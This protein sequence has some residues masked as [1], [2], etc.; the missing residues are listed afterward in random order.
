MLHYKES[1]ESIAFKKVI[2][3]LQNAHW[4]LTTQ[5]SNA[6]PGVQCSYI[7]GFYLYTE[8]RSTGKQPTK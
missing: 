6:A 4:S 2:S 1:K 3:T 7:R 8:I 5:S